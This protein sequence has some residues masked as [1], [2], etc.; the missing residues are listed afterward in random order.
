MADQCI[1]SGFVSG[2][3]E[4]ERQEPMRAGGGE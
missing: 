4:E 2:T 3:V 1:G